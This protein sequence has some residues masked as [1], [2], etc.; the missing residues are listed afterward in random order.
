MALSEIIEEVQNETDSL[1]NELIHFLAGEEAE[2]ETP[3]ISGEI[4]KELDNLELEGIPLSTLKQTKE[5]EKTSD[6]V[7]TKQK[8]VY[9][10]TN[11]TVLVP[12]YLE[13]K[14]ISQYREERLLAIFLLTVADERQQI[15]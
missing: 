10:S 8:F 14:Q 1:S 2:M 4:Q 3:E 7:I 11:N 6:F 12:R 13:T 5:N 9:R 15:L